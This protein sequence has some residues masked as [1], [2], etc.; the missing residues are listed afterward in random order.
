MTREG[1]PSVISC[2]ICDNGHLSIDIISSDEHNAS[3]NGKLCRFE[4][5][6]RYKLFKFSKWPKI[7]NMFSTIFQKSG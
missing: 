5:S 6:L 1:P 2:G 3:S 4:L 7:S